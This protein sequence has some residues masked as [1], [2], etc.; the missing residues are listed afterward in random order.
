MCVRLNEAESMTWKIRGVI[1]CAALASMA[2]LIAASS[3]HAQKP[4]AEQTKP[5]DP[6]APTP[7]GPAPGQAPTRGDILRGPY[8]PYRANNDLLSYALDIR[9]DPDKQTISG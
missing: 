4:A 2:L 9:A 8:G 3:A 7:N 5:K 6:D 1:R